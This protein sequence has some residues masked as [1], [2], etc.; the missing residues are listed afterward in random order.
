MWWIIG[1]LFALAI[2]MC[3]ALC[4]VSGNIS[5]LEEAEAE[6]RNSVNVDESLEQAKTADADNNID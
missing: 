5:R 6:R 1:V 2:P 3:F 4:K